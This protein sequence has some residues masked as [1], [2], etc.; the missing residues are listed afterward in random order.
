MD[1]GRARVVRHSIGE[2]QLLKFFLPEAVSQPELAAVLQRVILECVEKGL[3]GALVLDYDR[4]AMSQVELKAAVASM[5]FTRCPP[6][7]RLAVVAFRKP[8]Y[9][10]YRYALETLKLSPQ[11]RLFWDELEA[12]HWL[13]LQFPESGTQAAQSA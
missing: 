8:A 12:M 2:V 10:A 3:R 13:R 9:E 5:D 6:N 4:P 7:F 1:I 11:A